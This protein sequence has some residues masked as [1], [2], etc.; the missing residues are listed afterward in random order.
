MSAP[1][2][3]WDVL[4]IA[5][6][7]DRKAVRSA[8]AERLKAIDPDQDIAG[9]SRLRDARDEALWL[10]REG[11]A[12]GAHAAPSESD[13]N[14]WFAGGG[15]A[16]G[17]G[18]AQPDAA[19]EPV[20]PPDNKPADDKPGRFIELLFPGHEFTPEPLTREEYEAGADL[21]RGIMA[22]AQAAT[23]DRQGGIED[24]LAHYLA[25]S[26]PRSG[27]LDGATSRRP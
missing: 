25:S 24:W 8:Y 15:D 1:R 20:P 21:M 3:P 5:P 10:I 6:T 13:L 11:Q 22:D 2:F 4:G 18:E 12:T 26:W 27:P 7:D 23:V 17:A 14:D 16:P 19:A 9:Y